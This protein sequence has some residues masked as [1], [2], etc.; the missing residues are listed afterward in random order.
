ME[1]ERDGQGRGTRDEVRSFFLSIGGHVKPAVCV[2]PM[3]RLSC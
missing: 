2:R 3:E 1:T